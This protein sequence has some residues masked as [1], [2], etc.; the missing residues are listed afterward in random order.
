MTEIIS[1]AA[2]LLAVVH[3]MIAL[4]DLH[5]PLFEF[6]ESLGRLF[7]IDVKQWLHSSAAFGTIHNLLFG[8]NLFSE[9]G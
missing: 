1:D 2:V 4:A 7:A 6:P 8:C 3:I 5:M 9:G